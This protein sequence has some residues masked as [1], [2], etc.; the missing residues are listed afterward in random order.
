MKLYVCYGTFTFSPR[1]G[2]HPCG[3]AHRA[4]KQAGHEPE[5]IRSYGFG[6]LPGIFNA[7]PARREVKRLTG[8]Y[9]VPVLVADDGTVV[10][11][12]G[13]ITAWAE[14]NPRQAGSATST[15]VPRPGAPA[16]PD[17]APEPGAPAA[18]DAAPRP[19][20]PATPAPAPDAP[21]TEA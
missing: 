17:A 10:Q 18:P 12:S 14:A 20:A 7:T 6:A 1:P 3:H 5:V 15:P 13:K 11:G 9:W 21:A 19:G 2:G 8:N 4:L 16:T